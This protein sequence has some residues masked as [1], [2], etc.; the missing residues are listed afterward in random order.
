M[1]VGQL[2]RATRKGAGLTQE[3]MS[4]LVNISRSTISK[5][6]RNEMTLAT[7]DFIRWLQ[8]I[9]IR[10]TSNTTTVEAGMYLINGVDIN[11]LVDML[12]KVVGGFIRFLF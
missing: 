3:E 12:T 8:V 2:L 5:V 10:L 9:Q 6:E 7:E 1:N 11:L 4:P